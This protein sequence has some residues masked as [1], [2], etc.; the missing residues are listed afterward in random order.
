MQRKMYISQPLAHPV[1]FM[2]RTESALT[3]LPYTSWYSFCRVNVTP[4]YAYVHKKS[5]P[6]LV[7]LVCGGSKAEL[8]DRFTL[9]GELRGKR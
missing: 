3:V 1:T 2:N 5:S 7:L 4:N 8:R 9:E 6:I